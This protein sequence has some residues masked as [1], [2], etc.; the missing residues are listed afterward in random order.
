MNTTLRCASTAMLEALAYIFGVFV[1]CTVPSL[2]T[3]FVIYLEAYILDIESIFVEVD[4]L[5][6]RKSSKPVKLKNDETSDRKTPLLSKLELIM[7]ESWK[8]A[9]NLHRKVIRY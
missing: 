4:R 1:F 9:V 7:L 5:S 2:L 6:K 8:D 3:G